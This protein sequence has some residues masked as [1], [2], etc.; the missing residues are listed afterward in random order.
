MYFLL[1]LNLVSKSVDFFKMGGSFD[2][3]LFKSILTA[4]VPEAV[5]AIEITLWPNIQWSD[6]LCVC[7]A[8]GSG[9]ASVSG[10]R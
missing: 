6:I 2:C 1:T 9:Q 3:C 8:H 7:T 10:H 5:P 4:A